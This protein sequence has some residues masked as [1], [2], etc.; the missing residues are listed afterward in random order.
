[1]K[2]IIK[3]LTLIMAL[4]VAT[5]ANAQWSISKIEADELKG[6]QE[7]YASVYQDKQGYATFWSNDA[8]FKIGINEG[9]GTFKNCGGGHVICIV[10]LYVGDK[11]VKKYSQ[12]YFYIGDMAKTA[13]MVNR[14]S[15]AQKIIEHLQKKGDV[16]ILAPRFGD[17]DLDLR[18]P[19]N[20][21]L[22]YDPPM[23]PLFY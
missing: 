10:G 12:V 16:R 2:K 23:A 19:M 3:T 22:K 8:Y 9:L 20:K 5:H 21:D 4:F 13:T 7:Y 18:I 17:P 11:L 1:M 15:L 14:W 6:N